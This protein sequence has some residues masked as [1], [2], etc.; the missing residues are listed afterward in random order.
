MI[1][2]VIAKVCHDL[3]SPVNGLGLFIECIEPELS[4]ENSD[5]LNRYLNNFKSVVELFRLFGTKDDTEIHFEQVTNIIKNHA[6]L[7]GIECRFY[8]E[9]IPEIVKA[10][11]A[12]AVLYMYLFVNKSIIKSGTVNFFINNDSI[13]LNFSSLYNVNEINVNDI[14]QDSKDIFLRLA[15]AEVKKRFSK[16]IKFEKIDNNNAKVEMV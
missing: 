5:Q 13:N 12:K 10:W 14:A 9:D 2:S 1:S 7:K 6:N 15:K 8:K 3:I 11:F 4:K 16:E